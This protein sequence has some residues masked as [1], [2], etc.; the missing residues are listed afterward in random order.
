MHNFLPSVCAPIS[1]AGVSALQLGFTDD[2]DP[3]LSL[4]LIPSPCWLSSTGICPSLKVS[5][6]N[7][8]NHMLLR[9]PKQCRTHQ[10]PEGMAI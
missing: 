2:I 5:E 7:L 8:S 3:G 1:D 10:M 9:V 6:A 4:K